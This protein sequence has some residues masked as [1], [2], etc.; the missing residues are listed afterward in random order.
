MTTVMPDRLNEISAGVRCLVGSKAPTALG[1]RFDILKKT[2][3][4]HKKNGLK[5]FICIYKITLIY[6]P[7]QNIQL[8][9]V[10]FYHH[11]WMIN[12]ESSNKIFILWV[13]KLSV[14]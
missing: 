8:H 1:A 14:S 13:I 4:R 12:L 6:Q 3:K 9:Y 10:S 5:Y 11:L 7:L 2:K